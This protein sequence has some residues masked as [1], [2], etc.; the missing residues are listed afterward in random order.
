MQA[1]LH[2]GMNRTEMVNV[3]AIKL[4]KQDAAEID[5]QLCQSHWFHGFIVAKAFF[6]LF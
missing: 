2:S 5:L 6:I 3:I 4:R 1:T